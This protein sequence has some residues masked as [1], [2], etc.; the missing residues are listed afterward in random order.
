MAQPK[1][2]NLLEKG[3]DKLFTD[4]LAKGPKEIAPV[5]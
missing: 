5:A 1:I 4:S 3:I 2:N